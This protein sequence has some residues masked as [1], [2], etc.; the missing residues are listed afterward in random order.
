M[1]C[2]SVMSLLSGAIFRFNEVFDFCIELPMDP[3]EIEK[4]A[5]LAATRGEQALADDLRTALAKCLH[6]DGG[7]DEIEKL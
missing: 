7:S 4:A 2:N 3:R 5:D 1:E 6:G